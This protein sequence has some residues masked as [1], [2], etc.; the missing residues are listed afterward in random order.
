VRILLLLVMA[1]MMGGCGDGCQAPSRGY[2]YEQ[3]CRAVAAAPGFSEGDEFLPMDQ[4]RV[5]LAKNAGIVDVP[6]RHRGGASGE[7]VSWRTV[8]FK[9]V[10]R[11]WTVTEVVETPRFSASPPR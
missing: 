2:I 6:F 3:A 8:T 9:R 4:A 11:T 10:A 7:N 5:G 1:M